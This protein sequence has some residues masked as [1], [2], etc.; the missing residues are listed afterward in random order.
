MVESPS[1]VTLELVGVRTHILYG[2]SDMLWVLRVVDDLGPR[3][4]GHPL[5]EAGACHCVFLWKHV[6]LE[7]TYQDVSRDRDHK[8]V[9]CNSTGKS[10]VHWMLQ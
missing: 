9:G 3:K 4:R 8:I 2:A 6:D 7:S 1:L 10:F 5:R